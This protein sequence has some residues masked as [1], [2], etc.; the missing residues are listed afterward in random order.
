MAL[1]RNSRGL[2]RQIDLTT[3]V[4]QERLLATH[5]RHVV[6]FVDLVADQMPFDT[7]LDIYARILK[8]TPEQARNVG[9]RA[10]AAV[11]RRHGLAEADDSSLLA[12]EEDSGEA[13][14]SRQTEGSSGGRFDEVFSRVRRRIR[15]RVQD[16]LRN[17]INLAASRAEDALF[18][19]HVENSLIFARAL[20]DE[21]PIHE[22]VDL[23]LEIMS[24][25]DG[26]SD[27]IFNRSLR[28]VA[29]DVLPPLNPSRAPKREDDPGRAAAATATVG[30]EHAGAGTASAAPAPPA[31]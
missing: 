17:R 7:A 28:T 1:T 14:E 4:C 22:A 25:P 11:G 31:A 16:D 8:L 5:V 26:V 19:T 13:D 12:L 20:A 15:G 10:L 9:S 30:D 23:Y 2:Q 21:M 3:A 6:A 29:D 27:V 24:V 18:G